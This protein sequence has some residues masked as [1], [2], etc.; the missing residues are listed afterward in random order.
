MRGTS[1][2]Q[3]SKWRE[4]P[5]GEGRKSEAA[6]EVVKWWRSCRSESH[7]AVRAEGGEKGDPGGTNL[8]K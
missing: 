4:T 7:S 3:S 2:D 5:A 1:T 6:V 8:E